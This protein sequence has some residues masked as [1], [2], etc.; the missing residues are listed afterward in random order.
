MSVG[1]IVLGRTSNVTHTDGE[2]VIAAFVDIGHLLY[3]VTRSALGIAE[4]GTVSWST[5]AHRLGEFGDQFMLPYA[6]G[7]LVCGI[8]VGV[9]TFYLVRST[10]TAYQKRRM[11]RLAKRRTERASKKGAT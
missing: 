5:A 10:I 7:G 3:D 9:V 11:E 1:S 4:P 8:P 6:I 2:G